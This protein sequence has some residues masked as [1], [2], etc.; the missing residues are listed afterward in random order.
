L[1]VSGLL[2]DLPTPT[3]VALGSVLANWP[4]GGILALLLGRRGQSSAG[5]QLV[6]AAVGLYGVGASPLV[7]PQLD[8]T[9]YGGYTLS[10]LVTAATG[11]NPRAFSAAPGAFGGSYH[12]WSRF[13]SGQSVGNLGNVQQRSVVIQQ[14]NGW[15]GK[16]DLSDLYGEYYG[17]WVAP[18]GAPNVWTLCDAGQTT[19]PPFPQPGMADPTRNVVVP[20]PQTTDVTG[21]G[22]VCAINWELLLPVDGSLVTGLVNN[23]SNGPF[24]VTNRWLWLYLDGLLVNRAGAGDGPAWAYSVEPGGLANPAAAVGGSGGAATG[25][26]NVNLGADPYLTLDP[27]LTTTAGGGGTGSGVNQLAAVLSDG[28][29]AVLGLAVDMVYTPLYL[30]PR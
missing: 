15:F 1:V 12:L 25:S 29:G 6:G 18:L 22:S 30:E 11:W 5:A 19:I 24:A 3:L 4:T 23:P 17:P 7:T 2:G 9:A 21:G 20:R 16:A 26:I 28:T 8:A 14:G 13:K 27:R 10:A